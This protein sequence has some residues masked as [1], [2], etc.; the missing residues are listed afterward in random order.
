[1]IEDDALCILKMFFF[2]H[3][4]MMIRYSVM[5]KGMLIRYIKFKDI[6]E[7]T[8]TFCKKHLYL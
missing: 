4:I 7:L 6:V 8:L 5:I 3:L 2:A 1:M